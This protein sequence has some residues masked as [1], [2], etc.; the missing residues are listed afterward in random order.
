MLNRCAVILKAKQPFL[1]WLRNLPDPMSPDTTLER[2]NEDSHVYLFS[3][4]ALE[5]ELEELL[6]EYAEHMFERELNAWWTDKSAWPQDRT[7]AQLKEWF[8]V[9][10]HSMIEDLSW[11]ALQND[12]DEMP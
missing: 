7:L 9:S 5:A 11:D 3:E 2:V 10:S 8:D 6:K 1:D 4:Y 12:D